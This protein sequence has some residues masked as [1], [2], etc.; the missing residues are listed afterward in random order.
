MELA[1]IEPDHVV[2]LAGSTQE[3]E[4]RLEISNSTP[5]SSPSRSARQNASATEII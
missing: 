5:V 2:F 1:G 4:E 3:P